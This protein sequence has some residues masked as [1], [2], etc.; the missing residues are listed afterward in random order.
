M[1]DCDDGVCKISKENE[2]KDE[3]F[4]KDLTLVYVGDP[5]CSWCYGMSEILKEVQKFCT[6]NKIR[7]ELLLGGLRV[8]GGDKWNEPFKN[9]LKNEWTKIAKYTKKEFTFKLLEKDFFNYDTEP[10]CRA[11]FLAKQNFF[12]KKDNNEKTLEF[13][14]SIQ[15]KFYTKAQDPSKIEFYEELCKDFGL[16]FYSFKNLF[17]ARETKEALFEEFKNL[18]KFNVRGM[19]SLFLL[20]DS[21]KNDIT[22]GYSSFEDIISKIKLA[23]I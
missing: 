10:A 6:E 23:K 8:G 20:K 16:D 17:E 22:V 19:P 11:V 12:N 14:A 15:K 13:F 9:F 4:T 7:F 3:V 1:L 21:Y 18:A 5:M 2:R